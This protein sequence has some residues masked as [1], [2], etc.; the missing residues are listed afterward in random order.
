[1]SKSLYEIFHVTILPTLLRNYDRYS[2][3][4]GVEVR[5]PFL[6]HRI[7]SFCFSLPWTSKLG[8]GYTKR[9]LRDAMKGIVPDKVR[10]RK[11]KFGWNAPL[12]EWFDKDYAPIL[13][14]LENQYPKNKKL[15][16]A[17]QKFRKLDKKKFKD[18]EI[19][20]AIIQPFIWKDNLRNHIK[21]CHFY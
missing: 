7:V 3:A 9:I 4:S 20:W 21:S 2:M 8:G 6:D 15:V 16:M 14:K 1:M 13:A 18:G 19:L 12:Q 5:M 10:L 11:D 17:I